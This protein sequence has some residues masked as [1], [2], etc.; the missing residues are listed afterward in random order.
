M[1]WTSLRDGRD[2]LVDGDPKPKKN[3][4]LPKRL[5]SAAVMVAIAVAALVAGDPW[6]DWFIAAVVLATFVEFILLVVKA[7]TNVPYRLAAILAGA[8]YIGLAG[9]VLTRMPPGLVVGIVGTVIAIDTFAFFFGRTIGGPK[10]APSISPSKTWAGLLG[11]VVGASLWLALFIYF[12]ARQVSGPTTM[13]FDMNEVGTIALMG[14]ALAVAA[15]AGD[16][17]ESWLK[18]KA[19]VKDSSHLIPGHGGV[20]DRTDGIIP[21]VLIAGFVLGSAA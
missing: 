10:I 1:R 19:G 11:G 20:F 21:V 2:D 8:L 12:S 18:R 7:T 13:G 9:F 3:A 17:L 15:Q 5:I 14:L 4:D 16:F 6:L